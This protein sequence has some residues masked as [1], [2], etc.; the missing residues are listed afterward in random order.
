MV[1]NKAGLTTPL[2]FCMKRKIE[3]VEI[4]KVLSKHKV[5]YIIAGGVAVGLH[6]FVRATKDIDLVVDFSKDNIK[7]FAAALKSLNFRPKVPI[8]VLDLADHVKRKSWV[9][10]KN[11]VVMSFYNPDDLFF[12]IDV[13][14]TKDASDVDYVVKNVKN[15]KIRVTSLEELIKMKKESGR[16]CDLIDLRQLEEIKE[17][18]E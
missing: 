4:L 1:K 5:N 3:V 8:N 15:L 2:F 13:F 16:P 10:E 11:A 7:R 6:G 17:Q 18:Y 12:Q 14:L 9:E